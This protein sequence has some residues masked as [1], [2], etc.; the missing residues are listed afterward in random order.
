MAKN[1]KLTQ[2]ADQI[3]EKILDRDFFER[4]YKKYPKS[5]WDEADE[6]TDYILDLVAHNL[7]TA[8]EVDSWL[9]S[10]LR[11]ELYE[12]VFAGLT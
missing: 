10:G 1:K 3:Y 12:M 9:D 7:L 11:E 8:Q 6:A 4:A 5:N 2:R